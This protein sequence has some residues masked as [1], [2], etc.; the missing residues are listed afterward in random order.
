MEII[1]FALS[2]RDLPVRS[3][4]PYS[5]TIMW[6]SGLGVTTPAPLLS[7]GTILLWPFLVLEVNT[8]RD[9][10]P[11]DIVAPRTKSSWPPVPE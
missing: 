4:Q 10:P 1:S 3:T 8:V 7:T 6:A 2:C 11:S 5:V 9:F